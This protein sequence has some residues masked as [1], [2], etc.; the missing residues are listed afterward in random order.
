MQRPGI[1]GLE[2]GEVRDNGEGGAKRRNRKEIHKVRRLFSSEESSYDEKTESSESFHIPSEE[3]DKAERTRGWL[4]SQDFTQKPRM[5]SPNVSP[6]S[7][8]NTT[9]STAPTTTSP[10][11][12]VSQ[13]HGRTR[14]RTVYTGD[15]KE[16][17][18]FH[19]Q[20]V[21]K[22]DKSL[23]KMI[24]EEVGLEESKVKTWFNNRRARENKQKKAKDA[25]EIYKTTN[26]GIV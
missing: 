26:E 5:P 24:A 17:L 4:Q 18:E 10:L 1:S 11:T 9:S 21:K 3:E 2:L 19:Y 22:P 15:Q 20:K 16:I 6:M 25:Q 13:N 8:T 7:S 12:P 23:R 14:Q